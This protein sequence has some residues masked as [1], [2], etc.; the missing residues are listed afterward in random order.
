MADFGAPSFSLGFDFDFSEPQLT[1]AN[2]SKNPTAPNRFSVAATGL[3]DDGDNDFE[4][5]TVVDSDTDNQNSPPKLKRLRRGRPVEDT[6]SSASVKSKADLFSAV[7]V[8][9]DDIE[10]FSSPEDNH[11]GLRSYL[12]CYLHKFKCI[13]FL[14]FASYWLES[15]SQ[16]HFYKP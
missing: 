4:T 3:V 16:V 12:I 8:D 6:V 2:E 11:T 7:V 5:V 1:T 13:D 10:D 15:G 14:F 9:D